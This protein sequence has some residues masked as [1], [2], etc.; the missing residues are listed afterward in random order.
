MFWPCKGSFKSVKITGACIF[1]LPHMARLLL[2][3]PRVNENQM[4]Y[5]FVQDMTNYYPLNSTVLTGLGLCYEGFERLYAPWFSYFPKRL[6]FGIWLFLPTCA[7]N[8][9]NVSSMGISGNRT[10]I[11]LTSFILIGPLSY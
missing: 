4:P 8:N 6:Y 1:N 2:K 3:G 5:I 10:G 11:I 7:S 9:F